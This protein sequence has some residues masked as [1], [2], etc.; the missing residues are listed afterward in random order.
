MCCKK[1]ITTPGTVG[2]QTALMCA[3]KGASLGALKMLIARGAKVNDV[4]SE[5]RT[6]LAYALMLDKPETLECAKVGLR[7]GQEGIREGLT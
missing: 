3:A 2:N 7:G 5:G 4:D 6:A 1:Q